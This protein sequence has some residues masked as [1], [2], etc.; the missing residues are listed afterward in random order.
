MRRSGLILLLSVNLLLACTMTAP[1]SEPTDEVNVPVLVEPKAE[2]K[3]EAKP[4]KNTVVAAIE[5]PI[6]DVICPM[7]YA[8]VVCSAGTYDGKEQPLSTRLMVWGS[9]VCVGRL[10]LNKEACSRK[11]LPSKLGD[12]RCVPDATGGHCPGVQTVCKENVRPSVCTATSYAGQA[13]TG[14][15]K[16]TGTAKNECLARAALR[17]AAC[18]ANLDPDALDGIEC[19]G[20]SG[21][22]GL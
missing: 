5:C 17:M 16:I 8:P 19:R 7:N 4:A 2:V 20:A 1:T 9:N 12:V 3:V 11:L 6:S 15:Q 21:R 13:L 22:G 10:R 18:R 14:D